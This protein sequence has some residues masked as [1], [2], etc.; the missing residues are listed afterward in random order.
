MCV[1]TEV[2]TVFKLI[3]ASLQVC[4]NNIIINLE[5]KV[6]VCVCV[7]ACACVRVR[8]PPCLWGP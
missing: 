5:N 7:S 1:Y 2:V 8:A 4:T 6:C 3:Y